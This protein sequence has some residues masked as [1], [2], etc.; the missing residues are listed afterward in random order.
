MKRL[1]RSGYLFFILTY[2]CILGWFYKGVTEGYSFC[3]PSH[4]PFNVLALLA[5]ISGI[6][7]L[8]AYSRHE[9]GSMRALGVITFAF[10]VSIALVVILRYFLQVPLCS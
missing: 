10:G 5:G 7:T 4:D 2:I 8:A 6:V 3:L 9:K 1:E